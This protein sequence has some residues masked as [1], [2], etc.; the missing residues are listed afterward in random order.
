MGEKELIFNLLELNRVSYQCTKCKTVVV[1]DVTA[2]ETQVPDGCPCC[3]SIAAGDTVRR[4]LNT[5]RNL[6]QE[7]LKAS[8][9]VTFQFRVSQP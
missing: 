8:K 6:Y 7:A 3:G 9:Q 2:T 1:F 4:C 5:Y